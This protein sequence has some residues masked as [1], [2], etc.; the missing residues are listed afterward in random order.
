MFLPQQNRFKV[1][2]NV[3]RFPFFNSN[4]Y[5]HICLK[6]PPPPNKKCICLR[7]SIF[8]VCLRLTQRCLGLLSEYPL[9]A[10]L[11]LKA[12]A[13]A[14]RALA[15]GLEACV[16]LTLLLNPPISIKTIILTTFHSFVKYC[17]KLHR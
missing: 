9:R 1:F 2:N 10:L 8:S 14:R 12:L 4:I 16:H 3:H 6:T 15:N 5:K 13:K 11:L 17:S 7:F